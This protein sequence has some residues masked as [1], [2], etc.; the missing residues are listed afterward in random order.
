M[1]ILFCHVEYTETS[2]IVCLRLANAT[3]IRRKSVN[4]HKLCA[5][6]FCCYVDDQ[7]VNLL[8]SK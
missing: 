7:Y 8:S 5:K 1:A 4:L 6:F 3:A 2:F